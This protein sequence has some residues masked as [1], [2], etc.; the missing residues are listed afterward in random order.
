VVAE[1]HHILDFWLETKKY[2]SCHEKSKD[3]LKL[4]EAYILTPLADIVIW[5]SGDYYILSLKR[6]VLLK[7]FLLPQKKFLL[8]RFY[9]MLIEK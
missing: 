5:T 3:A 8:V 7:T 6:H 9:L 1:N 2:Y 4:K